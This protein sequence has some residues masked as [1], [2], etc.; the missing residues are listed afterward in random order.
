MQSKQ[1]KAMFSRLKRTHYDPR[2]SI[3]PE[4]TKY[5]T[6]DILDDREEAHETHS[7][8]DDSEHGILSLRGRNSITKYW[9]NNKDFSSKSPVKLVSR[10]GIK[11]EKI[12]TGQ[13]KPQQYAKQ[14]Q[15]ANSM[16]PIKKEPES[17]DSSHKA[18]F[19][20]RTN[21]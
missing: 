15:I 13:Q 16:T 10:K 6:R 14:I 2:G 9:Q 5:E 11:A 1:E 8:L 21:Y 3:L 18:K 19:T 12:L 20:L 17:K 7:N 4:H